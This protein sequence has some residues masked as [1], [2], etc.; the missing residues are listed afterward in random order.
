MAKDIYFKDISNFAL[1][2]M[3]FMINFGRK[4][5]EVHFCKVIL[6]L[7]QWFSRRGNLK[8]FLIYRSGSLF[9][10]CFQI[11]CAIM[12]GDIMPNISVK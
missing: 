9:V 10:Q 8:I 4:H 12:I 7:D 3:L 1:V 11:I 2:A 6:N 5:H